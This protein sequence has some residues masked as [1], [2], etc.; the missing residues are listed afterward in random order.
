MGLYA[1]GFEVKPLIVGEAP[2]KNEATPRP[3]EGCVGKR[4]AAC[5]NMPLACF[6]D[7]FDRVNLLSVRQD[8]KEKGFEFDLRSAKVAAEV[9]KQNFKEGQVVLFLG[10]RVAEV[11]G[12]HNHY[13]ALNI[14]GEA[15]VYIIPHP[16]G[17]NRWWNEDANKD[18]AFVFMQTIV[19]LTR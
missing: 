13:F 9:M 2:S 3:I 17:V 18:R 10:R 11:F 5:C 1:W 6:L 12:V 4:L 14:V 19:E 7:H 16:S 15:Q 8:T